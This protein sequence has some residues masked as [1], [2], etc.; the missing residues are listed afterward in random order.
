MFEN[1]TENSSWHLSAAASFF[2]GA[3]LREGVSPCVLEFSEDHDDPI[4]DEP[5][6]EVSPTVIFVFETSPV[7]FKGHSFNAWYLL[8]GG[9][10]SNIFFFTPNLGEMIQFDEHIFQRGWN[11]QLDWVL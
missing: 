10:N 11:H 2:T 7:G 8:L 4:I 3:R 9:G 5:I 1:P 6:W